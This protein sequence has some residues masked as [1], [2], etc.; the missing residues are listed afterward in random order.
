MT[1]YAYITLVSRVFC[2]VQVA[3]FL[4]RSGSHDSISPAM[5]YIK[6]SSLHDCQC[7]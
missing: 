5:I 6:T 7:M 2:I 3:L 1:D 4:R